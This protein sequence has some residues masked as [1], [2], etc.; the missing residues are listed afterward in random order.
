MQPRKEETWS[1][2]ELWKE[3]LVLV[4]KYLPTKISRI[5]VKK[6]LLYS[7]G[8]ITLAQLLVYLVTYLVFI[9]R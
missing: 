8:I 2:R 1:L 9:R 4:E 6:K 7:L 5:I 3:Y